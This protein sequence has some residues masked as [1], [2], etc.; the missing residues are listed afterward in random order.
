MEFLV[1]LAILAGIWFLVSPIVTGIAF[2]RI[3]DLDDRLRR[4]ERNAIAKAGSS[5]AVPPIRSPGA[6]AAPSEP[7]MAA[8]PIAVAEALT[9]FTESDP[10]VDAGRSDESPT[11]RILA[12]RT[13]SSREVPQTAPS[14]LATI[15]DLREKP[16]LPPSS[17]QEDGVALEELLVGK[18]LTWLG[19]IAVVIGVG[20]GIKFA[21]DRGWL[22][23]MTR[24]IL[25]LISGIA[26]MIG[27][28]IAMRKDYRAFGQGLAGAAVGVLY[29]T[30][31]SAHSWYGLVSHDVA[32]AGMIATTILGFAFACWHNSQTA[33]A[34]GLIGGF[35]TPVLLPFSG[36]PLNPL[37]TYLLILN[38]GVLGVNLLKRWPGLNAL[39]A[40]ATV[41]AWLAWGLH[42]YSS[43]LRDEVLLWISLYFVLFSLVSIAYPVVRRVDPEPEDFGL[44]LV[45]PLLYCLTFLILTIPSVP[46]GMILS[47]GWN[48]ELRALGVLSIGGYYFGLAVLVWQMN[49]AAKLLTAG[50]VGIGIALVTVSVPVYF[51][52][53]SLAIIWLAESVVL[54][55]LG[56]IFRKERLQQAGAALLGV[57]QL[58]IAGMVLNTLSSPNAYPSLIADAG[59]GG[60]GWQSL[61]NGRTLAMVLDLVAIG[62]L[63]WDL[64]RREKRGEAITLLDSSAGGIAAWL[65]RAAVLGWLAL[66]LFENWL[67]GEAFGWAPASFVTAILI[68]TTGFAFTLS[69]WSL[70][71]RREALE[72]VSWL[73]YAALVPV[74]VAGCLGVASNPNG[75]LASTAVIQPQSVAMLLAGLAAM[76]SAVLYR[77]R[78][79]AEGDESRG[80]ADDPVG[81]L[82]GLAWM[83]GFALLTTEPLAQGRLHDWRSVSSLLITLLWTGYAVATLAVGIYRRSQVVRWLALGL[84]VL[85]T[86]KAYLSDLWQLPTL[87]RVIAF[88]VLGIALLTT[89]FLYRRYQ[90]RLRTLIEA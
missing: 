32:Y 46:T 85:T 55:Q 59:A 83:I 62:G 21:I 24:V 35:L 89:S 54:V 86:L 37:F 6:D 90:S 66:A 48:D 33:A 28:S 8:K 5:P 42:F 2:S 18:W 80:T 41:I 12:A 26:M 39:A 47:L 49:R 17:R 67:W 4:M 64:R 58:L 81:L 84:L 22:G 56:L 1:L 7:P 82:G 40:A 52:G 29:L 23:P 63:A 77:E 76:V 27:A 71:V 36:N 31:V 88:L 45:T 10:W 70:F 69:L 73:L 74:I 43:G 34:L 72:P 30:C 51:R 78:R 25:S 44:M 65:I 9:E 61:V 57:V 19:A 53:H 3:G 16:Q 11:D 79:Q 68:W 15:S 60:Y 13:A 14:A 50:L 75:W 38:G 20:F 87:V